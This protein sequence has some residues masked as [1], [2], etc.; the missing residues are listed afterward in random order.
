V[1]LAFQ[2]LAIF[3]LALP[4]IILKKT[5]RNGFFWDRPRQPSPIAEEVA[6]SLVLA[7][8]LHA[9]YAPW[10]PVDLRSV[11]ALLIGEFDAHAIGSVVANPIRIF[12]YFTSLYAIA[13]LLGYGAHAIVRFARL[14]RRYRLLRFDNQWHYLLHGGIGSFPESNIH[15]DDYDF[16]CVACVVDTAAGTLLYVGLLDTFFF[17]RSGELDLI[18]LTGA[19]RRRIDIAREDDVGDKPPYFF[20]DAE[21]LYLKYSEVRNASIRYITIPDEAPHPAF[22]HPLPASRG[23]GL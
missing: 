23:E 3:A 16:V 8:A 1:N 5:F 21:Y 6:Y 10:W 20:I 2:A 9:I 14:D 7:C 22:G 19:M 17:N 11:F 18:V 12:T 15:V 13:A 4:G